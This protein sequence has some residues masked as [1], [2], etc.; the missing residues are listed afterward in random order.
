ML[1]AAPTMLTVL[2]VFSR[3]VRILITLLSGSAFTTE[4]NVDTERPKKRLRPTQVAGEGARIFGPADPVDS[5]RHF[6]RTNPQKI[7]GAPR[8]RGALAHE[9]PHA[10][11]DRVR[12]DDA[13]DRGLAVGCVGA[14]ESAG[15]P[16]G[17]FA[18]RGPEREVGHSRQPVRGERNP[19]LSSRVPP[20]QA[21]RPGSPA[22]QFRIPAK[23]R[24]RNVA[25]PRQSAPRSE[26]SRGRPNPA[27]Q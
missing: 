8:P 12:V 11:G 17:C 7:G 15:G 2:T 14:S 26:K 10:S 24:S 22:A 5:S 13:L 20:H 21:G 25:A 16:E 23:A 9:L 19:S 3:D 1:R 18:G 6:P 27:G 4:R